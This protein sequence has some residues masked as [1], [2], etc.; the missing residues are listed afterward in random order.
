M[1]KFILCVFLS[2]F[3]GFEWGGAVP[4]LV[5]NTHFYIS[6][7]AVY[8]KSE[9]VFCSQTTLVWTKTVTELLS[10]GEREKKATARDLCIY[11]WPSWFGTD[12]EWKSNKIRRDTVFWIQSCFIFVVFIFSLLPPLQL[13]ME[14]FIRW[15]FKSPKA[16]RVAP[17][18]QWS[19]HRQSLRL[20]EP[21]L[22][23]ENTPFDTFHCLSASV[24]LP[25]R[26]CWGYQTLRNVRCL[27]E[28]PEH[29]C[30]E[31]EFLSLL[32]DCRCTAI[33]GCQFGVQQDL[34]FSVA[35]KT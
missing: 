5:I 20:I 1:W 19:N 14:D 3:M 17:Y 8:W 11:V 22:S 2:F 33:L 34:S 23:T 10:F 18:L 13:N 9:M 15:S 28:K 7:K 16:M 12:A 25:T 29:Y 6:F 35:L 27:K 32:L 30:V 26:L 21:P 31:V 4:I 24:N